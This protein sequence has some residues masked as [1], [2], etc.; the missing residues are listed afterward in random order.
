[1]RL[2]IA[3]LFF[4]AVAAIAASVVYQVWKDHQ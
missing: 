2:A 3:T 1:M 4:L